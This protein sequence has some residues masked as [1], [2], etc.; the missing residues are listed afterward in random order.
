MAYERLVPNTIEWDLYYGNHKSRY[1][2]AISILKN[3]NYKKVLDAA[4]GVG[5]GASLIA[6]YSEYN[7]TA[8]DR[9]AIA[10]EIAKEKFAKSGV[11]F[12]KDDCEKFDNVKQFSPFDAI[13]S[14]E[15]LEHLPNPETFVLNCYN[16][17]QING[18]LIISTP[19]QSVSSPSGKIDWE[20]H[21]KEYTAN[22]L[23]HLLK[24]S[25]FA[26]IVIYG[27]ELTSIG[28]FREQMRGEL[29]VLNSNPF[30]RIGKWFQKTFRGTKYRAILPE[31]LEDFVFNKYEQINDI[32]LKGTQGPFVLVAVCRKAELK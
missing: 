11:Q 30:I 2:F 16:S 6:E 26:D 1:D 25:G 14:F 31:K 29:N 10:L 17:L 5:Y 20:F 8:I 28:K 3:G 24:N 27:Q 22:E 13:I 18:L 4:T 19:N 21:E 9:D 12:L 15:T 7:V 32:D 23:N